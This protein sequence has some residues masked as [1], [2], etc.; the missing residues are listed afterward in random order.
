VVGG[1]PPADRVEESF[2]AE[3]AEAEDFWMEVVVAEDCSTTELAAEDP[4]EVESEVKLGRVV[5]LREG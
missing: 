1:A 4:E 5:T 3:V 2:S